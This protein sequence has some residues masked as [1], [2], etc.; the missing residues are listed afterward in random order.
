MPIRCAEGRTLACLNISDSDFD[1]ELPKVIQE[2]EARI[3]R[4][5]FHTTLDEWKKH[6]KYHA[7]FNLSAL[8]KASSREAVQNEYLHW[9]APTK[10]GRRSAPVK[11]GDT[12]FAYTTT[13]DV[14]ITLPGGLPVPGGYVE[15][16]LDSVSGAVAN[17]TQRMHV[18][19]PGYI[20]RWVDFVEGFA[21]SNTLGRGIGGFP[22][23][24]EIYGVQMFGALDRNIKER[25]AKP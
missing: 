24:N 20:V 8:G 9:P 17:V 10:D 6:E 1:R 22:R 5:K 19:Y 14:S 4:E 12:S 21:V 13:D 2:F 25:L 15:H 16:V 7:Y 11:T 23:V 18:L 3:V